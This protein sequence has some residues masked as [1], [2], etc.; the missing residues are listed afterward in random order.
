MFPFISYNQLLLNNVINIK[1][2]VIP[3]NV[4]NIKTKVIPTSSG[5]GYPCHFL[6]SI[7]GPL[8]FLLPITFNYLANQ[9]T[10]SNTYVFLIG[11][12]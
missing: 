9:N 1:T 12:F 4:I 7:L 6:L 2:K 10:V 3:N 8:L 5:I 11:R